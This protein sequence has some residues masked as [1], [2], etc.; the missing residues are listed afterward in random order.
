MRSRGTSSSRHL[1]A[2]GFELRFVRNVTDVDD[3]IIQQAPTTRGRSADEVARK[4]TRGDA[5]RHRAALGARAADV[6][7]RATEHIA[8]VIDIIRRLV[9]KGLAY[10][11]G[12][13][14]LLRGRRA[15]PATAS[16]RARAS[17][18][19]KAGARIEVGEQKQQPARLRAVEGRQAGRAV[20]AEPVGP[21]PPRLAHRVLGDG[22]PLPRRAVRHPRRR[23]R[24]DLPAPRERDRAVRGRVR[25]RP[26]S[27]AT[28]CTRAC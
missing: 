10:A 19:C 2:S 23:R 4:Y 7:P 6:E 20:V 22:A 14:R 18:I 3:K 11:A 9:E 25:R 13:R 15:S 28:G 17:T 27:R 16:S 24:P 21:G 1:R 8:E 5:R 12:R 26:A